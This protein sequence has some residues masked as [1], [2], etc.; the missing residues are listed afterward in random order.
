MIEKPSDAF[1][2]KKPR[3]IPAYSTE[4]QEECESP[5]ITRPVA[6]IIEYHSFLYN[7]IKGGFSSRGSGWVAKAR[8]GFH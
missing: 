7:L 6:A 3:N 2:I 4:R 5:S 1:M 8:S